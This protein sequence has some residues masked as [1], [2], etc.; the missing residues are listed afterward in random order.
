MALS[1]GADH[2]YVKIMVRQLRTAVTGS[3][4]QSGNKISAARR[5]STSR[6]KRQ[7]GQDR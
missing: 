6:T 4:T 2:D 1:V 3:E 7:S 5:G